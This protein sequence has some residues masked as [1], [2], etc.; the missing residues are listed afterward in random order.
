M[1]VYNYYRDYLN[2]R[3]LLKAMVRGMLTFFY[4]AAEIR[5][6]KVMAIWFV[7]ILA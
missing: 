7:P 1:Q 4:P 6:L 2:D 5:Y 3:G